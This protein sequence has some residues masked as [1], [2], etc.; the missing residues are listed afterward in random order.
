MAS[1]SFS[2]SSACTCPFVTFLAMGSL[3]CVFRG[4]CHF[5]RAQLDCTQATPTS[6]ATAWEL[7]WPA[8]RGQPSTL[9]SVSVS[10]ELADIKAYVVSRG[11]RYCTS[12]AFATWPDW[13]SCLATWLVQLTPR[14]APH[15]RQHAATHHE[16]PRG[17]CRPCQSRRGRLAR[18]AMASRLWRRAQLHRGLLGLCK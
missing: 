18:A 15:C 14:H 8:R 10:S 16:M 12:P 3:R 1:W 2:L 4:L 9:A 11:Q 5:L 7:A 17:S 6:V 13:P